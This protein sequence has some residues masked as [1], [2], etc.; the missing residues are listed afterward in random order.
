MAVAHKRSVMV[1]RT[2]SV[3]ASATTWGLQVSGYLG[4]LTR[5]LRRLDNLFAPATT[6]LFGGAVGNLASVGS[7]GLATRN[8]LM[9]GAGAD[10]PVRNNE[11]QSG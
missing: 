3:D 5:H 2:N 6:G 7:Q 8:R 4:E 1:A 10:L 9:P 11:R